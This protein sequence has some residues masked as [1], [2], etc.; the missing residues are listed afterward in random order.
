V[1]LPRHFVKMALREDQFLP[2]DLVL[3]LHMVHYLANTL[4][5][6]RGQGIR[7]PEMIGELLV[8]LYIRFLN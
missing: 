6:V 7:R 2:K 5:V 8:I 3:W 1:Q 4:P